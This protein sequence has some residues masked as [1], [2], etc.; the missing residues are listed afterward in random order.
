[1]IW[2]DWNN[3]AFYKAFKIAWVLFFVAQLF[4]RE[5][6]CMSSFI[7]LD[8]VWHRVERG[9]T[10][11]D[12]ILTN[13]GH[14]ITS[15]FLYQA[16]TR[17]TNK[18]PAW[19]IIFIPCQQGQWKVLNDLKEAGECHSLQNPKSIFVGGD[20]IQLLPILHPGRPGLLFLLSFHTWLKINL[21]NL[22]IP[23]NLHPIHSFRNYLWKIQ[24]V[25][26]HRDTSRN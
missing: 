18:Q 24:D 26:G 19:K 2:D 9:C 11:V 10:V 21:T 5:Q 4:E 20:C 1:M 23:D 14:G 13:L 6:A 16:V 15:N 17:T 12:E 22:I 8:W 25:L 7:E 3:L